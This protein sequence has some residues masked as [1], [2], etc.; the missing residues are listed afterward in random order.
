VIGPSEQTETPGAADQLV[1]ESAGPFSVFRARESL[2]ERRNAALVGGIAIILFL[3][4][5]SFIVPAVSPYG[6]E[7]AN[8]ADALLGPSVHHPFGTDESGF[9]IMTRVFYAARIDLS[10]SALGVGLG[11]LIGVLLGVVAGFARG[12]L[13]ELA[14]RL[15]DLIQAFPLFILAVALVALS[16]NHLSNIVWALAFLT[17]PIF[18]RLIRSRVLTIREQRYIEAAIALGNPRRRLL[19]RHVLPNALSPVIV[20]FGISM[21][22]AILTI[23]G[24]AFLGVGVQVP[25][26]EWGSMILIGRNN[27]TTGQWWTVVFPGI[28]L[29]LAVVGLNLLSEGVERAREVHR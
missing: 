17:T 2:R 20:Q 23:A 18:L 27:I 26:P 29:A 8:P 22:Y 14:M 24:L 21:G 13:G 16:G 9:D 4:L 12:L 11:L 1:V 7:E 6:P 25:T 5:G 15:V 3:V 10:L 19:V 28:W